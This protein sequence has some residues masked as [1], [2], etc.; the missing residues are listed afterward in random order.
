VTESTPGSSTARVSPGQTY[1]IRLS[2]LAAANCRWQWES[3]SDARAVRVE[4]QLSTSDPGERPVSG[5]SADEVFQVTPRAAGTHVVRFRQR[6][7]RDPD[8]DPQA[9]HVLTLRAEWR[10]HE[11]RGQRSVA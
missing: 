8:A 9:E 7:S 2:G 1:E 10:L 11:G 6:C 5:W 4:K 3:T